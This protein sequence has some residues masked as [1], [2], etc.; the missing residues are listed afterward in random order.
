VCADSGVGAGARDRGNC[1]ALAC[2]QEHRLFIDER[3][4]ANFRPLK[5]REYSDGL[6]IAG[7]EASR[8]RLIV[9]AVLFVCS[10]RE[11]PARHIHAGLLNR[12]IISGEL[13]RV[14]GVQTILAAAKIHRFLSEPILPEGVYV[15]SAYFEEASRDD[16][17]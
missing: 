1:K 12:S 7:R 10:V 13:L 6:R 4:G 11:I 8:S 2:S 14:Q 5:I 15:S 3:A 16:M 17:I 9:R